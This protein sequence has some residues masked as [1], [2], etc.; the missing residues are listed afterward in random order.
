MSDLPD[1]V[2]YVKNGPGGRW[3]DAAK[4]HDQIHGS[5]KDV[6]AEMLRTANLAGIEQAVRDWFGDRRGATQDFNAVR[7]LVDRPSQ[8]VWVTFEDGS[9]WWATARDDLDVN[10]EGET[11]ERGHFWINLDRPWSN[12]S[13]GGRSLAIADVPGVV[14]AVAGF[15]ATVCKPKASREILRV[16]KDEDDPDAAA[17]ST[18][19][20]AYERAMVRLVA[21]LGPRD[22][23]LLVDL[24]LSRTGWTRIARLG[25]VTAGIDVEVENPAINEIAF[26]QVK[27]SAGR[28]VLDDYVARFEK[29]RERYARMIFAVHSPEGPLAEPKGLPVQVWDGD[30]VSKL[31]VRLGLGDWVAKRI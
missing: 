10:P 28:L 4:A 25:G 8:H 24:I 17:A 27:A 12:Q 26:V 15:R 20:L 3:W 21:R 16:I 7:T 14:A 6:P 22:F 23:E 11:A 19:R 30:K 29:Q 31:V 13:L 1:S 9:L 5:W 2:R 18:A